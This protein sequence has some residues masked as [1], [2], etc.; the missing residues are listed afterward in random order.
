MIPHR[1][2]VFDQLNANPFR[3]LLGYEILPP[4]RNAVEFLSNG[5]FDDYTT[6]PVGWSSTLNGNTRAEETSDTWDHGQGGSAVQLTQDV[7]DFIDLRQDFT[8][9]QPDRWYRVRFRFRSTVAEAITA[10]PRTFLYFQVRN[11][12]N[13]DS[14]MMDA[15]G[16]SY[17]TSWGVPSDDQWYSSELSTTWGTRIFWVKTPS[18]LLETDTVRLQFVVYKSG[19]EGESVWIDDASF[20]GPYDTRG[21]YY[22]SKEATWAGQLFE[23]LAIKQ[24]PIQEELD[25]ISLRSRLTLGNVNR[26][27]A[28]LIEPTDLLSGGEL[29]QLLL[30]EDMSTDAILPQ[31]LPL[32]LAR[33]KEPD[34]V[35]DASFQLDLEHILSG[36]RVDAPARSMGLSCPAQFADGVECN[37][38]SSTTTTNAGTASVGPINVADGSNLANGQTIRVGTNGQ[39]VTIASGGGTNALTVDTAISWA[40]GDAVALT[41]C[42]RELDGDGG[43]TARGRTH[44]Y[45]GLL[46]VQNIQRYQYRTFNYRFERPI[47]PEV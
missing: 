45:L 32:V 13:G 2:E 18:D 24:T 16:Q 47:P 20:R 14:A 38:T 4:A 30:F 26:E 46:G 42:T 25:G 22:S 34:R 41:T 11:T 3:Y 21:R 17:A 9:L 43:C 27:L 10:S 28:G 33:I 19:N 29:Q 37:Y 7:D 6:V 5:S 23:R 8:G 35:G 15:G 39:E 36:Y 40:N 44:E 1:G 31:Y 12:T